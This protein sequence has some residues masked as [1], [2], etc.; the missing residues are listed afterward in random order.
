[1]K[2][3]FKQ[4][5]LGSAIMFV[6]TFC[7]SATTPSYSGTMARIPGGTFVRGDSSDD[8]LSDAPAATI[9]VSTFLLETNLVTYAKWQEVYNWAITNG[10]SFENAGTGFG[11]D[12][13]VQTV[14]WYD[15]VKWCN[16]RSEMEH[17]INLAI[18][19]CYYTDSSLSTDAV[20]RK[21]VINISNDFVDWKAAGYR[22][23]TEAEW[24]K[25]ARGGEAGYRFPLGNTI[26]QSLAW[27]SSPLV[28]QSYDLGPNSSIKTKTCSVGKFA[29]NGFGLC[30]MSGNV[31]EW[32]WDWYA[33]SY[34]STSPTNDP[35]GP[36]SGT[37]RVYRG[38]MWA[39]SAALMR[40][41]VRNYGTPS[42]EDNMTGFRCAR[43]EESKEYPLLSQLSVGSLTYGQVLTT[44]LFTYVFTN[45]AGLTIDGVISISSSYTSNKPQ[46][47]ILSNVTIVFTPYDLTNYYVITTNTSVTINKATP[48]ITQTPTPTGIVY[49][50]SLGSSGLVGGSASVPGIFAFADSSVKPSS[51]GINSILVVFQPTDSVD[52]NSTTFSVNLTV[53]KATPTVSIAP[54]VSPMRFGEKLETAIFSGGVVYGIGGVTDGPLSGTF[55]FVNSNTIASPGTSIQQVIFYPTDSDHYLTALTNASV[56]VNIADANGLVYASSLTSFLGTNK[57]DSN[58]LNAILVSY[59]KQSPDITAT[60]VASSI[61]YGQTVGD[62]KL[63]GGASVVSGAFLFVAPTNVLPLGTNFVAVKFIPDN[64][65]LYSN[66][67]LTNVS[68]SVLPSVPTITELPS[69]NPITY[70]STLES[71]VLAGGSATGVSGTSLAGT[72]AFVAPSTVAPLGQSLQLVQFTPKSTNYASM[73]TNVVVTTRATN[74]DGIM[75][76]A[77]LELFLGTGSTLD[78]TAL[79][80]VLAHYSSSN[81]Y[82]QVS[83][84]GY[85]ADTTLT[86]FV[87]S[88]E[89]STNV[90]DSSWQT[91]AVPPVSDP[92]ATNSRFYRLKIS[93]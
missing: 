47:G 48:T 18:K 19:P 73:V 40:C 89:Y 76:I 92:S 90:T 33:I 84:N 24:E 1:M 23:P 25:A 41:A 21:G 44:N 42:R 64:S 38:G 68:I 50:Q 52:Y 78:L 3:H 4:L 37:Y 88:V 85:R 12:H 63:S 35:L 2:H 15:V 32:C 58:G 54:T 79:N 55:S 46:A 59:S 16:A 60:P 53:A 39:E 69:V 27:Y 7:S 8:K 65:L 61:T 67:V 43:T 70:G 6:I 91:L 93:R 29:R 75:D 9:N 34:Y 77:S 87:L 45:A 57:L 28:P 36:V 5:V 26:S 83:A 14:N 80:A 30:D 20:Y 86:N 13:P 31:R 66:V 56:M 17:S 10:Y 11:T 62:S 51:T 71:V 49:G 81:T 22:L 74:D 72:F 82:F